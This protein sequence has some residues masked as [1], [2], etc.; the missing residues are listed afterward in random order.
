MMGLSMDENV[1]DQIVAILIS[2]N[3][4][5]ISNCRLNGIHT[6]LTVDQWHAWAIRTS[7]A[8]LVEITIEEIRSTN[9]ETLLNDLRSE[10]IGAIFSGVLQ[11]VLNGATFVSRG[12]MLAYMLNAPVAKL[13]MRDNVDIGK[14]LADARTLERWSQC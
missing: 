2:S 7:F 6:N 8:D 4:D 1:L 11:D 14:D 3:Y 5:K 10:L 13:T 9:F 12:T